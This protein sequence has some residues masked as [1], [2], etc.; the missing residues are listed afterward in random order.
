MALSAT[1]EVQAGICP[2]MALFPGGMRSLRQLQLRESVMG[3]P[4]QHRIGVKCPSAASLASA[5]KPLA[6]C[7]AAIGMVCSASAVADTFLVTN[8]NDSGPNS[9]RSTVASAT[10]NL[11]YDSEIDFDLPA[12]CNSTITLTTGALPIAQQGILTIRG[13]DPTQ[14]IAISGDGKDRVF[15]TTVRTSQLGLYNL[16]IKNGEADGSNGAHVAGGCIYSL[17]SAKLSYSSV[18]GCRIESESGYAYGGGIFT[19]NGLTL[20]STVVS[21]NLSDGNYAYGGGIYATGGLGIYFSTISYNFAFGE[22]IASGGGI[23]A[24]S[25]AFIAFS[26]IDNNT[27]GGGSRTIASDAGAAFHGPARLVSIQSSTVSGNLNELGAGA[28]LRSSATTTYVY[29]STIAFNTAAQGKDGAGH[30]VAPGLAVTT[31]H[32]VLYNTVLAENSYSGSHHNDFSTAAGITVSGSNNMAQ[33]ATG[34]LPSPG[35]IFGCPLLGPLRDNGG[36]TWTH[37]LLSKSPAIDAGVSTSQLP[38]GGTFYDQREMPVPSPSGGLPDI[39]AYEV[40]Q[41]DIVF[42]TSFEGC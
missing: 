9:L 26:T 41:D 10:Q 15:S 5:P 25:G 2:R 29:N 4:S 1:R 27:V 11:N 24:A 6:A 14:R 39:G 7:L 23:S 37:A 31:G 36:P 20:K 33:A 3:R 19:A 42:N 17:G 13:P 18:T 38:I 32:L 35:L 34:G 28:G 12:S 30:Y 16:D 40:Q 8:C 21:G 22:G